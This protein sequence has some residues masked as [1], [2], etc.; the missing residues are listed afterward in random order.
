[1]QQN[2]KEI[3]DI[4]NLTYETFFSQYVCH[5][6]FKVNSGGGGGGGGGYNPSMTLPLKP[7][8]CKQSSSS[9]I[10]SSST[11]NHQSLIQQQHQVGN[12]NKI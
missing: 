1:M 2:Y 12:I 11:S 8:L 4:D 7:I 5:F 6:F 3:R 9:T 10:N